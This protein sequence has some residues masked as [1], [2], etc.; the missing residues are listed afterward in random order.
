MFL[1]CSL[2]CWADGGTCQTSD[3]CQGITV[4]VEDG[5]FSKLKGDPSVFGG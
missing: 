2:L 5:V 1:T 4:G 3:G